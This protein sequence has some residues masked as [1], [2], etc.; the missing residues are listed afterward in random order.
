MLYDAYISGLRARFWQYRQ[1]VFEELDH[2]FDRVISSGH[3]RMPVFKRVHEDE[4]VLVGPGASREEQQA[5]R[6][7]LPP[8]KRHRHF[9][10]MRS[11]QALA[12]T[13]FANL[14]V[15]TSLECLLEV[16]DERGPLFPV[17][18]GQLLSMEHEIE[19]LGE[20]YRGRTSVDVMFRGA[21]RVAVECK[22]AEDVIGRCSR[23]N[24]DPDDSEWC[25][26]NYERQMQ[27]ADRCAL[28]TKGIL[29]W[30]FVPQFTRWT[31]ESDHLPC[32][33][34]QTYQLVRNLLAACVQP[35]N[36]MLTADPERGHVVLI[37][38]ERNPAFQ[39][40]GRGHS[41]VRAT[42][43]ALRD[44]TRLRVC[45]WQQITAAIRRDPHL[46]WLAEGL[47][48]KYGF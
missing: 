28:S 13:V 45:S 25:N 23:P 41:A 48:L 47:N 30:A 2:H 14:K 27:G 33:L 43:E 8:R 39:Q 9:A 22:L 34:H 46:A 19:Y 42:L 40:G 29:Y 32:P 11:S 1:E 5:V 37:V 18:D 38:D 7:A 20:Q 44:P 35:D 26:G 3:D 10:S 31:S 21:Y 16:Q 15:G 12:Q 36:D 17:V 24:L 4:N 6:I